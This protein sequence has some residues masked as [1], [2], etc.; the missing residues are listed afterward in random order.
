MAKPTQ[1]EFEGQLVDADIL[2]SEIIGEPWSLYRLED[3]TTIKCKQVLVSVSRLR[4]KHKE[5]GEPIYVLKIGGLVDTEIPRELYQ[6]R[7]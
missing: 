4:D 3:G 7:S 1:V 2:D 6:A 5:N